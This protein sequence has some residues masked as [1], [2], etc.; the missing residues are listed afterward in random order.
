M[1]AR[2]HRLMFENNKDESVIALRT[3][4][5]QEAEFQ[6]MAIETV[7]GLMGKFAEAYTRPAAKY[8][9]QRTFSGETKEGRKTQNILCLECGKHHGIWNCQEFI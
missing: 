5:L 3:W 1:L 6:T 9:N 7:R 4:I 2:Y 8:G